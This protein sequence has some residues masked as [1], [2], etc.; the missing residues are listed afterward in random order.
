MTK[1][2]YF[3]NA[4]K[5][6]AQKKQTLQPFLWTVFSLM[7]LAGTASTVL[8]YIFAVSIN[9]FHSDCTDTLY[10]AEAAMQGN[11]LIN[12]DFTYATLM[13]LGGNLFMQIWI[14]LF[15]ISM[16]TQTLGMA[17]FFVTFYV[18]L[19]LMLREMHFSLRATAITVSVLLLTLCSSVKLREIFWNH[20]IYYSLGILF[21]VI[22]LFL[23]LH[24]RNLSER[25][26]TKSVKIQTVIFYVLLAAD[27]I[28][29]CTNSTTSIALFAL[30]IL[31]G[32]F[33]ERVLDIRTPWKSRK[34]ATA[35]LTLL[36]CAIG[37]YLGMKLGAHI[38]GDV[39]EGYA[40]A[41]SRFSNPDTWWDHV[42]ALPLAFLQ[43]LG[44]N[45]QDSDLL[46]SIEGVRA[47]LTI[48][49][50]LFL[51]IVPII[52]LCCYTKIEEA[53][54]RVLIWAH[55]VVTAF[56][57]VGYLCGLL[58]AG[59]WRLSPIVCT[60]VLVSLAFLH[61]LYHKVE[62]RRW[63]VLLC[64]PLAYL[65][66]HDVHKV[67]EIPVNDYK[68][69]INYKLGEYLKDQ[70]LTYGYASFWHSQTIT[71]LEDSD[72]KIRTVNFTDDERG[73][74]ACL[75]QSNKNWFEDQPGQDRYFL[76]MQQD[77]KEKMEQST[78]SILT[79]PHEE[80]TYEG[81]TIWIFDENIF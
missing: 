61:W 69:S 76:L 48:F 15:G 55:W 11:G 12:P 21:L 30:P 68:E 77:E 43:L 62:T 23:V 4:C 63:C 22:G 13:P 59:I 75:Y 24:I 10:W 79:L 81:Y 66:L 31:G 39:Q 51:A 45:V 53:G 14:P 80:Q 64:L 26:Q 73:L 72:V 40:N 9:E 50:A 33:C 49:Y 44:L 78:S 5:K 74:E 28:I 6:L 47:I 67:V 2:L 35:L 18:F 17:T 34:S 58:S 56:I 16:K 52:A 41:Y 65:C 27:F 70:N 60:S 37:L 38:D 42:E 25:R 29:C 54:V 46:A 20:I 8:Y 19:C 71:V 32:V 3:S 57:L 7:L 1:T 36:I